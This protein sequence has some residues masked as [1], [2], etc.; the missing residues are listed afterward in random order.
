MNPLVDRLNPITFE[1]DE[2]VGVA[3]V[4][5]SSLPGPID[6][7]QWKYIPEHM[8]NHLLSLGA[9]YEL[10]FSQVVE[11]V[12]DTVL[13]P[14]QCESFD[15]ELVFLATVVNDQALQETIDVLRCEVKNVLKTKDM[16]LVL[17]PP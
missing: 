8:W 14:E 6:Q 12:I 5:Q 3:A 2:V 11:P 15:E 16:R 17:S 1:K 10:H 7:S 13:L 4:Q 9:G